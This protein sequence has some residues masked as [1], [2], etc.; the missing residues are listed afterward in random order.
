M[1]MYFRDI[2]LIKNS[3]GANNYGQIVE[4]HLF[5]SV[6]YPHFQFFCF[7]ERLEFCQFFEHDF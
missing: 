1:G 2:F 5:H 3:R 4:K 7:N 6:I